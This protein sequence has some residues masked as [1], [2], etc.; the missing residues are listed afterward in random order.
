MEL[1]ILKLITCC[2]LLIILGAA[3]VFLIKKLS[4]NVNAEFGVFNW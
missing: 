3:F 1:A 2:L 4:L